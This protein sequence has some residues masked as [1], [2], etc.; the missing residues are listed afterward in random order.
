MSC[1]CQPTPPTSLRERPHKLCNR[2]CSSLESCRLPTYASNKLQR[3]APQVLQLQ[4]FFSMSCRL[5]TYIRERPLEL[6]NGNCFSL[7]YSRCQPT[8]PTSFRE[9]PYKLWNRNCSSLESCRL[10]TYASNKLQRM[11]PEALESQLFLF[12]A[13]LFFLSVL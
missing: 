10:P 13:Q 8:P 4:L 12:R 3:T 7:V 5:P 6:C 11:A 1:R 2:N 9:W